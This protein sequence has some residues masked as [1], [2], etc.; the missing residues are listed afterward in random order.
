VARGIVA[1]GI[2]AE[3][4]GVP[5]VYTSNIHE[6]GVLFLPCLIDQVGVLDVHLVGETMVSAQEVFDDPVLGVWGII[7]GVGVSMLMSVCHCE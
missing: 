5:A 4:R 6:W 3:G 1:R 2:V 7:I